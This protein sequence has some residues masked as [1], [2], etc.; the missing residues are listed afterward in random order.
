MIG[1]GREGEREKEERGTFKNSFYT[2]EFA[3]VFRGHREPPCDVIL[4]HGP[5]PAVS[6]R[7]GIRAQ[8]RGT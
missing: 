8:M 5:A 7:T 2:I 6:K 4:I 1:I 3:D